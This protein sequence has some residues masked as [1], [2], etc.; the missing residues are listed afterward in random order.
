MK[1]NESET[2]TVDLKSRLLSKKT[3]LSFLISGIVLYFLATMIDI[4][5]T[6]SIIKSA[7]LGYLTLAF[8][9]YYVAQVNY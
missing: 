7:D 8:V 3:I 2:N 5:E 6:V 4:V 1:N 9:V